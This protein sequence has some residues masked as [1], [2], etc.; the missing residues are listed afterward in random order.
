MPRGVSFEGAIPAGVQVELK[1][2]SEGPEVE[3]DPGNKTLRL[4]INVVEES[5]ERRTKLVIFTCNKCGGRTARNVN[6]IAWENGMVMGQC[7]TCE[8]WHVLS[9]KNKNIYEEIV[10]KDDPRYNGTNDSSR[11]VGLDVNKPETTPNPA[12]DVVEP[13]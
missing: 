1:A 12:A 9:A 2:L 8:A 3:W 4:P 11:E 13:C 10:Y 5:N 6:P 7:A